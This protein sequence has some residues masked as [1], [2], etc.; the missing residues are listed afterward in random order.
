MEKR[1]RAPPPGVDQEFNG[2]TKMKAIRE[3]S[4]ASCA[5]YCCKSSCQTPPGGLIP[6]WK[7][8]VAMRD[9]TIIIAFRFSLAK[10]MPLSPTEI[11]FFNRECKAVIWSQDH[12]FMD[13]T[14]SILCTVEE[15]SF[16]LKDPT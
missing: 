6:T 4:A 11:P 5:L 12:K 8:I 3:R 16:T 14:T 10:L 13:L 9:A 2:T 7:A 1:Q 15:M